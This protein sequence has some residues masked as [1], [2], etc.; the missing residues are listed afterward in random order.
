MKNAVGGNTEKRV[1]FCIYRTRSDAC[2]TIQP[3][4]PN[5]LKRQL[6]HVEKER[7]KNVEY[8][9]SIFCDEKLVNIVPARALLKQ[10]QR[11]EMKAMEI[12]KLYTPFEQEQEAA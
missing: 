7:G 4:E 8:Y 11:K 9:V 1:R 10:L 12:V 3:E 5:A 6:I 2:P